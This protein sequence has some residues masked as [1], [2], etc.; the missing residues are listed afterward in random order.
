R[1][2]GEEREEEGTASVREEG[3]RCKGLP[4]R[5]GPGSL[6]A[7]GPGQ[8][9]GPVNSPRHSWCDQGHMV[10]FAKEALGDSEQSEGCGAAPQG[11]FHPSAQAGIRSTCSR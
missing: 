11:G 5:W 1:E 10:G 2:G 8:E 4:K 9:K 3:G 6:Q 7:P